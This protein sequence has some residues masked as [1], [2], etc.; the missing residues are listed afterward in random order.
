MPPPSKRL[1]LNR[2]T[3]SFPPTPSPAR[4]PDTFTRSSDFL[5]TT[6]SSQ[7]S[8]SGN[9][10]SADRAKETPDSSPETASLAGDMSRDLELLNRLSLTADGLREM[11]NLYLRLKVGR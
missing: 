6:P 10:G 11:T 3:F 2:S 1:A 9:N 7:S 4:L 8:G 5:L